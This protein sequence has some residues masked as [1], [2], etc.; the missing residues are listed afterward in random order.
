M[1]SLLTQKLKPTPKIQSFQRKRKKLNEN[2]TFFS[3][4]KRKPISKI[5]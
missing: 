2:R 5:T 3:P 4:N 1:L